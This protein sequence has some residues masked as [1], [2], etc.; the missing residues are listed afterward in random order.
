MRT[1][2]ALLIA[3]TAAGGVALAQMK[4]PPNSVK[5]TTSS[6]P[7][8]VEKNQPLESARR[9]ARDEAI[10]LVKAGKAVYVDVRSRESYDT[11]HIEGAI[12]IP[13]SQLLN[14][15]NQLP[16]RKMIIAYCA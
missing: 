9:I 13:G 6:T 3:A 1:L 15:L 16:P 4:A 5:V 7:I 8:Q 11:E 14:K 12:S 2:S 10:R